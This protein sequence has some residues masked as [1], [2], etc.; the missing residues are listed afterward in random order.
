MRVFFVAS[1]S[2]SPQE[3]IRRS[4]LTPIS[5]DTLPPD[6]V[7]DEIRLTGLHGLAEEAAK[8]RLSLRAGQKFN[9]EQLATA[10]RALNQLGWFEDVS[11]EARP[12]AEANE[13]DASDTQHVELI[14]HFK[15]YPLLTDVQ[16]TGSSV[17]TEP[18]IKKFLEDKKLIPQ[19]GTPANPVNL[20]LA[21]AAI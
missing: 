6:A 1:A 15:Q 4:S 19:I 14:V 5:P 21:A 8:S 10:I 2:A 7:I 13:T 11:V 18:R 20:H 3:I 17:L 9:P 12:L 16:Y